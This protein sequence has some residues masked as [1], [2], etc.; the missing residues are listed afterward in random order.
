MQDTARQGKWDPP[1][2]AVTRRTIGWTGSGI[3]L[4]F[5][6]QTLVPFY[7]IFLPRFPLSRGNRFY[8][9]SRFSEAE[10]CPTPLC[11]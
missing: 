10:K 5:Q 4:Q 9:V 1:A 8:G 2:E 3:G 11:R 6:K 7:A